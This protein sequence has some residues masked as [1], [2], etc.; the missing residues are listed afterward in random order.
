MFHPSASGN[1]NDPAFRA[2]SLFSEMTKPT[3]RL[4]AHL[5]ALGSLA[6]GFFLGASAAMLAVVAFGIGEAQLR[7]WT[8][9]ADL[10]D[11]LV[12]WLGSLDSAWVMLAAV[13]TYLFVAKTEGLD[14]AR[15]WTAALLFSGAALAWLGAGTGFPFGALAFTDNLGARIGHV[16]PWGV[17]L[18]WMVIVLNSR[19]VAELIRPRAGHWALAFLTAA[20][21]A[22]IAAVFEAL[23]A[24][25][26]FYWLWDPLRFDPNAGAPARSYLTWFAASCIFAAFFR[27]SRV[28]TLPRRQLARPAI[29]AAIVALL[30]IVARVALLARRHGG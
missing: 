16:L 11:A 5:R 15:R 25:V 14:T 21:A 26:R 4:H 22:L 28:A 8:R 7:E 18:L 23:A 12:Y 20:V 6:W 2:A 10:Q 9:G 27:G 29:I 1:R 19:Y 24:R 13:N 17:P 3:P 30:G